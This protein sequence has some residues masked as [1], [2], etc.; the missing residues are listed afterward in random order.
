[1]DYERM[2]VWHRLWKLVAN[3]VRVINQM[4]GF[5]CDGRAENPLRLC[6]SGMHY[7]LRLC[8]EDYATFAAYDIDTTEDAINRLEALNDGIW[9]LRRDGFGLHKN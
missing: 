4:L 1:M 5:G 8:G 3:R 6:V 9:L 7:T 2:C